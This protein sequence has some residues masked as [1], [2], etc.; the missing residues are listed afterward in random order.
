MD[1]GQTPWAAPN[2]VPEGGPLGQPP[3]K[4]K[5][6][7]NK[8]IVVAALIGVVLVIAVVWYFVTDAGAPDYEM[9]QDEC[10]DTGY[11]GLFTNTDTREFNGSVTVVAARD[12]NVVAEDS[13]FIFGLAPGE[14]ELVVFFWDVPADGVT[15][16]VQSVERS[17]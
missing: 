13:E 1:E 3:A 15:C 12:G 10:S 14:A 11:R 17:D 4:G 6:R 8:Y 9:R 7:N 2:P 5:Q 16:S